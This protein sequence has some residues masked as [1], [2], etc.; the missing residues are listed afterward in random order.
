MSDYDPNP[1]DT[2]SVVLGDDLLSLVERLAENS[3]D[4]WAAQRHREGWKWGPR[5]CDVTKRHPD[6]IP[7]DRLSE[8]EKAYDRSVVTATIK[9]IIA[10]GF[11]IE[12]NAV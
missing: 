11:S 7:Y 6:L 2:S 3:H 10:L 1:M 5:R 12:R 8:A 4:T 9:A